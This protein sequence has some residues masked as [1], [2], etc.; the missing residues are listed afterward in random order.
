MTDKTLLRLALF[1]LRS[2]VAWDQDHG[3][4]CDACWLRARAFFRLADDY[5]VEL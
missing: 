1:I 4:H 5:E 3:P 2:L